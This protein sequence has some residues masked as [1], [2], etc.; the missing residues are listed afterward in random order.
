MMPNLM[1]EHAADNDVACDL[2]FVEWARKL[3]DDLVDHEFN[4]R[5]VLFQG[6]VISAECDPA[7]S[8]ARISPALASIR[9]DCF[10]EYY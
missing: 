7:P 8:P 4:P 3:P 9:G 2:K 1:K 10:S 5:S 6:L